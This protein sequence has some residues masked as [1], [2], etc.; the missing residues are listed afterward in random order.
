MTYNTMALKLE[1]LKVLHMFPCII[2]ILISLIKIYPI[3]F[4]SMYTLMKESSIPYT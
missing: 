2:E 1:E 4:R 3:L